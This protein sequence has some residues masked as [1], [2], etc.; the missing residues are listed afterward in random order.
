MEEGEVT[1]HYHFR[2]TGWA[3]LALLAAGSCYSIYIQW[4]LKK[5]AETQADCAK[6]TYDAAEKK[7]EQDR[8]F[9]KRHTRI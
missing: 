1:H 5:F 7:D 3:T 6:R 4:R 8:S 2:V 9:R